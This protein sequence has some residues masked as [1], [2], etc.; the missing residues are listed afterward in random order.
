MRN[1]AYIMAV[2]VVTSAL[3]FVFWL[4][5]A[6]RFDATQVG[7]S[8]ALVSAMTLVSLLSNL[9][10]NTALV[11][12]LPRRKPGLEWSAT[13]NAG[14]FCGLLSSGVAGALTVVLLPLISSRFSLLEHSLGYML[15]FVGGVVLTTATNLLDYACI[16]ER[17]AE[18]TLIRNTVFSVVKIP[19]LVIPAVVALG[20]FGVFFSWVAA[21]AVTV[22]VA[23]VMIPGLGRGY[24]ISREGVWRELGRLR[25]YIA[26]HHSINIGNF[27]PWWLLPVF[28]T[29]QVSAASTAY[30][31]A[32]WRVCG[33]LFL[34]SPSVAS[35]FTAEG[36]HSPD[37]L[38]HIAARTQRAIMMLLIPGCVLFAVTGH[39]ILAAFGSEY[40]SAAL[41]LLLLFTVAS[42]PDSIMDVWV[43]VLRVEGRLRFGSWLQ[44]G[45]AAM[46]LIM[47]WFLLPPLGISGAGV[48]WLASRIVGVALVGWDYRRQRM[49]R[50]SESSPS[51]AAPEFGGSPDEPDEG[52]VT[53]APGLTP[54]RRATQA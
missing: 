43:G 6:R 36:A 40:A 46:A 47:S 29:I 51:S 45:T 23:A 12:M 54:E 8:A 18:K 1:S 17:R 32:T 22:L 27:A 9:G 50:D 44:L 3:G 14:L 38:W 37:R 16:A 28:V 48:G 33:L 52:E 2:T 42:L 30:F 19:V 5:A 25:G 20:T 34:I 26:G 39:W 53:S 15:V 31:Y 41:P 10:I 35:A 13:L 7:L 4:V 24:R 49:L 11:Q 21:T